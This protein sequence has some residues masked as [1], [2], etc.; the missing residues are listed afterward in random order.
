MRSVKRRVE[1]DGLPA[2]E[3]HGRQL[4]TVSSRTS[5]KRRWTELD[6]FRTDGGA[7]IKAVRGMS[8]VPGEVVIYSAHVYA[9]ADSCIESITSERRDRGQAGAL[10]LALLDDAGTLDP[11]LRE[12]LER[13]ESGAEVIN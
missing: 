13:Y 3:F 4:A 11:E 2:L 12:A 9:D 8:S 1:R 5:S 6:L 7:L 10:A